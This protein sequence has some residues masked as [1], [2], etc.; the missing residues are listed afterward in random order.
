MEALDTGA[1]DGNSETMAREHQMH[2]CVPSHGMAHEEGRRQATR[3]SEVE[4]V[5]ACTLRSSV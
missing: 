1:V 3:A 2:P 5:K 4:A